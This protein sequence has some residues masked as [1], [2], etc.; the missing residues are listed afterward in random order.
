MHHYQW[1]RKALTF[2]MFNLL[3][4]IVS[5]FG[6]RMDKFH[7]SS[8]SI[9]F[10]VFFR[11]KIAQNNLVSNNSQKILRIVRFSKKI[12]LGG[13]L[14]VLHN[15]VNSK[16]VTVLNIQKKQGPAWNAESMFFMNWSQTDP[17]YFDRSLNT[18][19][20]SKI[21]WLIIEHK[22]IRQ[23]EPSQSIFNHPDNSSS[24]NQLLENCQLNTCTQFFLNPHFPG[25]IANGQ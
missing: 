22:H 3:N 20:Q 10:A 12:G 13:I 5:L 21:F 7:K 6:A 14:G 16:I 23:A 24:E 25:N 11:W 19:I 4:A 17:R 15:I 9:P 2:K 8:H 1:Q 18:S